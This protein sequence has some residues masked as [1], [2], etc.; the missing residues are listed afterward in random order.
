MCRSH[1]KNDLSPNFKAH[2]VQDCLLCVGG[3]FIHLSLFGLNFDTS[4]VA[5]LGQVGPP[6]PRPPG[7]A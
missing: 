3:K 2:L 6:P 5:Q 7:E 4:N 1:L